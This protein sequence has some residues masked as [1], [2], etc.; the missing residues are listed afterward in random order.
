MSKRRPGKVSEGWD[1]PTKEW[2]FFGWSEGEMQV[3]GS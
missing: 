1:I 2:L 3:R